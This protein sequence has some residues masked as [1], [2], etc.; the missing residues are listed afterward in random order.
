MKQMNLDDTELTVDSQAARVIRRFGGV[1]QMS[2]VMAY[3]DRPKNPTTI[4]RWMYPKEVG[5]TGGWIPTA[6]WPDILY[7]AR[8]EG[9]ILDTADID[10]RFRK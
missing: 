9:I 1:R 7:V 3:F 6:A 4:Y 5:G 8:L 10:P 2:R